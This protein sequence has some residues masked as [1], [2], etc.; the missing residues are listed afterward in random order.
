MEPIE[1]Y[2]HTVQAFNITSHTQLIQKQYLSKKK[3]ENKKTKVLLFFRNVAFLCNTHNYSICAAP[4]FGW[5]IDTHALHVRS[6]ATLDTV[7]TNTWWQ[8][9]NFKKLLNIESAIIV[10]MHANCIGGSRTQYQGKQH[11]LQQQPEFIV[12]LAWGEPE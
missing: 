6:P 8:I 2:I 10:W 3:K 1:T 9:E 4:P 11:N 12:H 5:L 7:S